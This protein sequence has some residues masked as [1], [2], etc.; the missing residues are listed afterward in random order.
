MDLIAIFCSVFQPIYF[1]NEIIFNLMQDISDKWLNKYDSMMD[2]HYFRMH[3]I[4]FVKLIEVFSINT[5]K[6][7]NVQMVVDQSHSESKS[8]SN[9]HAQISTKNF[10]EVFMSIW[11]ENRPMSVSLNWSYWW[12]IWC[13]WPFDVRISSIFV[14][15]NRNENLSAARNE[16]NWNLSNLTHLKYAILTEDIKW[17]QFRGWSLLDLFTTAVVA[18]IAAAVPMLCTSI[19]T[20]VLL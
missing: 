17:L 13:I 18:A 12:W 6:S 3:E 4:K 7:V 19:W 16:L 8:K 10:D 1:F 11:H 20:T 9:K 14:P 2:S 15:D 5:I